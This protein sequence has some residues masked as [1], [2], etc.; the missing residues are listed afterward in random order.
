MRLFFW[1]QRNI[2]GVCE[3]LI[4]ANY[5]YIEI[6]FYFLLLYAIIYY[7]IPEFFWYTLTLKVCNLKK[8]KGEDII[9][10]ALFCKLHDRNNQLRSLIKKYRMFYLTKFQTDPMLVASFKNVV[11]SVFRACFKKY[12][13]VLNY[14][15]GQEGKQNLSI[16]TFAYWIHFYKTSSHIGYPKILLVFFL[17]WPYILIFSPPS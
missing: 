14:M 10:E 3:L 15:H 6:N 8:I 9:C 17:V 12:F 11:Q 16:C 5:G 13:N 7:G 4:N 2:S 1:P